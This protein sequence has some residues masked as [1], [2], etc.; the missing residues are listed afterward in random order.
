METFRIDKLSVQCLKNKQI[1]SLFWRLAPPIYP[2]GRI[3]QLL[4]GRW[5]QSGGPSCG[6]SS[7][8]ASRPLPHPADEAPPRNPAVGSGGVDVYSWMG[9]V[10]LFAWGW[11]RPFVD[12]LLVLINKLFPT[13]EAVVF[14]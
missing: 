3:E 14:Q 7:F 13:Y 8:P 12:F 1:K 6:P 5:L 10:V 4:Q 2:V 11:L 9:G